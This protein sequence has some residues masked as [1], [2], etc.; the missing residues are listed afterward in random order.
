MAFRW[1]TLATLLLALAVAGC[2]AAEGDP[3]EAPPTPQF[4]SGWRLGEPDLVALGSRGRL[5]EAVVH[6]QTALQLEPGYTTAEENLRR[7]RARLA[8]RAA[9]GEAPPGD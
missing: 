9:R 1:P 6:F 5:R 8:R 2:G 7:T 3:A 4:A